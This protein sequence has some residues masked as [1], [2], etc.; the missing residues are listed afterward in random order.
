LW[1]L[2]PGNAAVTARVNGREEVIESDV[3]R[4]FRAQAMNEVDGP[5]VAFT[6]MKMADGNTRFSW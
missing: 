1:V 3:L 6:S 2:N 5:V 4:E